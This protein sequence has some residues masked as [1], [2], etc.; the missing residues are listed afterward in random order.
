MIADR[1]GVLLAL[2]SQGVAGPAERPPGMPALPRAFGGDTPDCPNGFV[3]PTRHYATLRPGL[4]SDGCRLYRDTPT[5]PAAAV[6]E[7]VDSISDGVAL[8]VDLVKQS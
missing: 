1:R 4:L 8:L 6:Y 7:P 5:W 3:L 2:N